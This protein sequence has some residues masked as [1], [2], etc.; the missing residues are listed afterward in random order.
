MPADDILD[1]LTEP[2][3]T[4]VPRWYDLG[5]AWTWKNR[6]R[7]ARQLVQDLDSGLTVYRAER[8]YH[9]RQEIFVV[10]HH[11]QEAI[12]FMARPRGLN[13]PRAELAPL[14]E[15]EIL[16]VFLP[17]ESPQIPED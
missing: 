4:A 15:K 8:G 17:V 7:I 14:G 10:A 9:S 2:L 11:S 12:R 1:G 3:N 5:S 13:W 6:A 16:Q